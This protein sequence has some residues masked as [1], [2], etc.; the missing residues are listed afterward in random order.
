MFDLHSKD[1]NG[2]ISAAKTAALLKFEFLSS[3]KNYISTG[4]FHN[5]PMALYF[6]IKFNRV[7]YTLQAGD[8]I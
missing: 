4:A 3:F 8:R 5:F 7:I 2:N 1:E 6:K